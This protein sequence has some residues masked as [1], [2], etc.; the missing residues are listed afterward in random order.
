[1]KFNR[2]ESYKPVKPEGHEGMG[3]EGRIGFS[4]AERAWEERFDL[5]EILE[6]ALQEIQLPVNRRDGWLV[7]NKDLYLRPEIVTFQPL[8][9]RGVRIRVVPVKR[10]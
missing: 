8:E 5:I 10:D 3:S 6:N 7:V 9:P 4:N 2:N 1:M